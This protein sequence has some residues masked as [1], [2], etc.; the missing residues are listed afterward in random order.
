MKPVRI[1]FTNKEL[2][3]TQ[4]RN[5]YRKKKKLI[6]LGKVVSIK[7]KKYQVCKKNVP[8]Y[9]KRMSVISNTRTKGEINQCNFFFFKQ[10]A[11]MLGMG[12]RWGWGHKQTPMSKTL[13]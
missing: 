7:R 8:R 4:Y 1:V 5:Q 13:S 9:Q 10:L 3:K 12:Q 6:T 2:T 11:L